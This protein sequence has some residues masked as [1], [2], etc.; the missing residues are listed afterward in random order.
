MGEPFRGSDPIRQW[1]DGADTNKDGALTADEFV[2]DAMRF[3][4]VLD[5][6]KD[7]EIDPDDIEFYET[8]L[9]P[10]IRTG[11]E[12]AAAGPRASG[13]GG[14]RGGG[15]RGGGGGGGPG[16]GGMGGGQPGGFS[17]GNGGSAKT[18]KYS[19]TKRGA[20]RFS[21]FDYPEPVV[22]ADTNFNRGV[23]PNEF[24]AAALDRFAMLDKNHDGRI[25]RGELPS[26]ELPMDDGP[27]WRGGFGGR[28]PGARPDKEDD[29]GE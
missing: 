11:G 9:A 22:V 7:G 18:P 2:A 6:G 28:P 10:E 25:T 4:A 13:G 20:A 29:T 5:R 19:D 27:R 12:G 14:R 23:D 8:K 26:I 3:F 15:R 24:R 1:F 21:F 17:F 16:G